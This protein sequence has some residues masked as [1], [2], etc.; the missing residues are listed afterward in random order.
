MIETIQYL[1][2]NRNILSLFKEGKIS[3]LNITPIESQ[4]ILESFD[5]KK[6]PT[7]KDSYLLYWRT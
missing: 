4:L 6:R 2:K 5:L 1:H 3:L 7:A